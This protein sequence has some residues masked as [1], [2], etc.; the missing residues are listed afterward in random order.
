MVNQRLIPDGIKDN[1]TLAFN[2]LVDRLGTIDITPLLIYLIDNVNQSA[3]VHLADQFHILGNEG[4]NMVSTDFEKRKLIKDA[5]K[6]HRY[7]GTK[8]SIVKALESI[9]F[10][11]ELKEWFEYEG[12][13]YHFKLKLSSASYTSQDNLSSKICQYVDE[14]KNVRS[15]LENLELDLPAISNIPVIGGYSVIG[16]IITGGA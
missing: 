14:Y 5:I 9:G 13:P 2:E 8:Y 4:W 10:I 11:V 16:L 3:L 7:K 6:N 1:S 15:V 12:T